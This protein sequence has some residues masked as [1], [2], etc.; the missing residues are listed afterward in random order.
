[1]IGREKDMDEGMNSGHSLSYEE[2][3]GSTSLFLQSRRDVGNVLRY[4]DRVRS[5]PT[6]L[7]RALHKSNPTNVPFI[8]SSFRKYGII[9]C[10]RVWDNVNIWNNFTTRKILLQFLYNL[11]RGESTLCSWLCFIVFLNVL[12]NLV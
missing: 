7:L 5:S 9:K 3:R 2:R 11:C 10:L 12:H 1:M 6:R 4:I 8:I